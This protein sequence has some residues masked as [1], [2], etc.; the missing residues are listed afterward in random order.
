MSTTSFTV[1]IAALIAMMIYVKR[2][3]SGRLRASADSLGEQYDPRHSSN[4]AT[5]TVNSD[6][7]TTSILNRD[8]CF[9]KNLAEISCPACD[10]SD[11]SCKSSAFAV[12]VSVMD[13]KT[14]IDKYQ[15]RKQGTETVQAMGNNL[16]K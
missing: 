14:R 13:T 12:G 1:V 2:G 16:W 11:P 7:T 4:T 3:I 10:P 8:K 5:T 6:V 15:T 9:D